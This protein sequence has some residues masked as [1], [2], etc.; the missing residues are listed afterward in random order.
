MT[1]TKEELMNELAD[2]ILENKVKKQQ[3]RLDKFYEWFIFI[4]LGGAIF[5]LISLILE[6]VFGIDMSIISKH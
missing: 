2:I 6:G 5:M 4:W 3:I 1:R